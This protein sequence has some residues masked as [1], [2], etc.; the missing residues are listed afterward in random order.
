MNSRRMTRMRL[1]TAVSVLGL[2]GSVLALVAAPASASPT[3]SAARGAR[4]VNPVV[5][6]SGH[7][8]RLAHRPGSGIPEVNTGSAF[9][10]INCL[11]PDHPDQYWTPDGN[12]TGLCGAYSDL[13]NGNDT[14][15]VL[16]V[17]GN[18]TAWG[19]P[20]IQWEPQGVCNNQYWYG[21]AVNYP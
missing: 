15:Y 13:D 2:A 16:G 5:H 11:G 4:H 20:V 9:Q 18:S 19:A 12:Q 14:G 10:I 8:N 21:P 7:G 6:I 1:L 17:S 3:A